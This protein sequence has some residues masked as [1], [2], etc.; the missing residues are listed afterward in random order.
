M[1]LSVPW[2][3]AWPHIQ[4]DKN[5]TVIKKQTNDAV[6]IHDVMHHSVLLIRLLITC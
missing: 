3:E 2:K 5:L 1:C 4:N 6:L